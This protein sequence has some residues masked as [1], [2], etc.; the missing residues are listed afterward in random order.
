MATIEMPRTLS[1]NSR[2]GGEADIGV[3]AHTS[4]YI[5]IHIHFSAEGII[6][7][8]LYRQMLVYLYR[9]IDKHLCTCK[10]TNICTDRCWRKSNVDLRQ[11]LSICMDKPLEFPPLLPIGQLHQSPP[12]PVPGDLGRG[13]SV[14]TSVD[15]HVHQLVSNVVCSI[16]MYTC[17]STNIKST[18]TNMF[19]V[20]A[21]R[22]WRICKSTI[23]SDGMC[24]DR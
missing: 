16:C 4:S 20:H 21:N 7:V 8:Y 11:H 12:S 13:P 10:S 3:Y 17:K 2:E 24:K 5:Y 14:P 1:R 23:I 18:N 22:Y 6:G 9:Q 19:G 15:L